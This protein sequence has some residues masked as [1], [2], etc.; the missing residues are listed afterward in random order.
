MV[1][2]PGGIFIMGS[3]DKEARADEKPRHAVQ[4]AGFW[5]DKTTVTNREFTRFVE[6]TGYVTTAERPLDLASVMKDLPP[7][8]PAPSKD[9]LLP[10]SLVFHST[11]KPVDDFQDVS[12]WWKWTRG[13]D[14][15]HPEGPAS[16]I[17]GKENYPVVQVSYD[18]ARAY[19][20]WAGKRLPTEAEWEFAA[21]GGLDRKR[22]AW[23]DGPLH[24]GKVWKANTWQGLFPVRDE[25]DDG[26][27]SAAPVRSFPP[28][29]YGL[30]D[31]AGNVWQ[32]MSDWYRPDTY[33][34]EAHQSPAANPQGPTGG[35][36][37]DEPLAAKRVIRGGSFLCNDTY[38][39][40]YRVSARMKTTPDS[41][42]NHI[43]FRC[44]AN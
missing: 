13:A 6:K 17:R 25:A 31:M 23:G 5:M 22:Y 37:P 14:W 16:S 24:S 18:D 29:G 28:N 21:R 43:G 2:I 27:A 33:A 4:V 34:E 12:Q 20:Q 35:Y 1:W 32:W 41:A 40:G 3:D 30:Y 15:R 42:T 7:G 26:F 38:C 39:S 11:A 44:V 19:A 8:T 10:S 9:Q 36:D